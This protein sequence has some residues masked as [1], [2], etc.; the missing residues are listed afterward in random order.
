MP[1]RGGGKTGKQAKTNESPDQDPLA[2]NPKSQNNRTKNDK[3]QDV[4][5]QAKMR[6]REESH[7]SHKDVGCVEQ[8][9]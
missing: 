4:V 5:R 9:G 1:E 6:P 7:Q 2:R 3:V 8:K